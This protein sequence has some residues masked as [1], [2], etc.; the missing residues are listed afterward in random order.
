MTRGRDKQ[1]TRRL[2]ESK[3]E[4]ESQSGEVE[5]EGPRSLWEDEE[6]DSSDRAIRSARKK[7][8]LSESQKE[9][10][11]KAFKAQQL[12][13]PK[14]PPSFDG[15]RIRSVDLHWDQKIGQGAF[16]EV[17]KGTLWGQTVALKRMRMD[18][19]LDDTDVQDFYQEIEIMK[20]LRHPHTLTFL[21][22]CYDEGSLCIVSEFLAGGSLEELLERN[23]SS[24]PRVELSL[25]RVL[26]LSTQ[27]ARGLNWL[28]HKG[29]I[30]RDLK[31]ANI[32][33]DHNQSLKIADFGLAHLKARSHRKNTG[34]YGYVGTPCYMAPEVIQRESYGVKADVFSLGVLMC[35]LLSGVYPFS[36][37]GDKEMDDD[38]FDQA[39]VSGL[40]PS[41]PARAPPL[42]RELIQACWHG[43][44]EHRP[45]MDQVLAQ[46]EVIR[47]QLEL[48]RHDL[49]DSPAGDGKTP[50]L[51]AECA[52]QRTRLLELEAANARLKGKLSSR[53]AQLKAAKGEAKALAERCAALEASAARLRQR[54]KALKREVK[55]L[56]R[57]GAATGSDA[58]GDADG[59]ERQPVQSA[60]GVLANATQSGEAQC[61]EAP[62]EDEAKAPS[63]SLEKAKDDNKVEARARKLAWNPDSFN[64]TQI[65][66]EGERQQSVPRE[67]RALCAAP[68]SVLSYPRGSHGVTQ[69]SALSELQIKRRVSE[70]W[71]PRLKN[72]L[73]H[74]CVCIYEFVGLGAG[75]SSEPRRICLG[76]IDV[77][78]P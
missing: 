3:S 38:E 22:A 48:D 5:D 11:R 44:A 69:A 29:V 66:T 77:S 76:P 47:E 13:R 15:D 62:H 7:Q 60:A 37:S 57:E 26:E 32:L 55:H 53:K 2:D 14:A 56:V 45:L 43:D 25:A 9:K 68:A 18:A 61:G 1:S 31:S 54:N 59:A 74:I 36:V 17:W 75:R 21:G 24:E 23:L 78:A 70:V 20:K 41:V 34:F 51:L 10:A 6:G 63:V 71:P 30:H 58:R 39:I 67:R 40:R 72:I 73:F 50:A 16:G 33:L 42:L 12:L 19:D 4:S 65:G 64:C 35:E 8:A 46:L 28:H 27:L 52:E 49:C